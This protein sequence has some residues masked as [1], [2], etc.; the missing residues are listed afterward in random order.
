[1]TRTRKSLLKAVAKYDAAN[2]TQLHFKLNNKTD[3]DILKH[4]KTCKNK[5][6]Y[7]KELIRRDMK[8]VKH[9]DVYHS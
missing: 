2:T 6:G 9:E 8:N 5:Q 7:I 3:A 4:L 1:M